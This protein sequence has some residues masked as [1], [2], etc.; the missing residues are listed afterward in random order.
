MLAKESKLCQVV[1]FFLK[2]GIPRK[3]LSVPRFEIV[4]YVKNL[5][6]RPLS[7]KYDVGKETFFI[8]L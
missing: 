4:T 1:D 5:E 8:F 7:F 6:L 2:K 3:G